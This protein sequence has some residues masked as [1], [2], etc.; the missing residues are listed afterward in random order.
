MVYIK[1]PLF[2]L[3]LML[4]MHYVADWIVQTDKIAHFKQKDKWEK[5]DNKYEFDYLVVLELHSFSW[6]FCVFTPLLLMEHNYAIILYL[7]I[8]TINNIIHFII[9]DLKANK[10]KINLFE[11]QIMHCLQI[12]ISF[13]IWWSTMM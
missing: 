1:D 12:I 9:D 7:I 6:S 13:I 10:K 8:M 4:F 3:F 5:Y 2:V 11:D